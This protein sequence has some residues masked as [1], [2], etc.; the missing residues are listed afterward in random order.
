MWIRNYYT[1]C[2][3]CRLST[4][5]RNSYGTAY[6]Y[7]TNNYN[8]TI[9]TYACMSVCPYVCTMYIV[10]MNLTTNSNCNKKQEE[11]YQLQHEQLPRR[12]NCNKNKRETKR[13]KNCWLW[14][15]AVVIF[16][17]LN[18]IFACNL[19]ACRVKK[20]QR[21]GKK[22]V[23]SFDM[24]YGCTSGCQAVPPLSHVSTLALA[25]SLIGA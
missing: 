25:M 18:K 14:F 12:K 17:L 4:V 5:N 24:F 3:H 11:Q 13:D 23:K 6:Y 9:T 16:Y 19:V 8:Y 10:N 21:L 7:E 20:S 22:W 1:D 15:W 2:T